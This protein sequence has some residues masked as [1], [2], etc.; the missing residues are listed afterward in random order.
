[1]EK[2]GMGVNRPHLVQAQ[3]QAEKDQQ[4][5]VAEFMEWA[6]SM[7]PGAQYMNPSS[8]AQIRQLL[9][10]D[11]PGGWGG[12]GGGRSRSCV[13]GWVDGQGGRITRAGGKT[14]FPY[15]VGLGGS[16]TRQLFFFLFVF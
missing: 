10:P 7:V 16:L 1:M 4:A 9:F 15:C 12:G 3:V 6:G 11:H 13:G 8:G 5:A 2:E 14:S